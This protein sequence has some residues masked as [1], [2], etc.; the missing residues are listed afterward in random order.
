V[1]RLRFCRMAFL[2]GLLADLFLEQ[3]SQ[4]GSGFV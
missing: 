1:T 4:T 2:P 3:I